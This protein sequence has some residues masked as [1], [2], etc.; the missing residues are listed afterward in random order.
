MF[1]LPHFLYSIYRTTRPHLSGLR[2][3]RPRATLRAATV[4]EHCICTGRAC[5][6]TQA[7]LSSSSSRPPHRG[8]PMPSSTLEHCT[9]TVLEQRATTARQSITSL[10]QHRCA[11]VPISACPALY[12]I[13]PCMLT[14]SPS[15]CAAGARACH[16]QPWAHARD[17]DWD[18]P[19]LPGTTECEILPLLSSSFHACMQRVPQ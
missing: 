12:C 1:H 15:T 5:P 4:S 14:F 13:C 16:V 19:Q 6:R 7:R 8:W 2:R 9:T 18:C 10:W 17:R 3:Q 11:H